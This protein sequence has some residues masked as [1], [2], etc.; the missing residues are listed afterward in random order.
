MRSSSL[1][2][3]QEWRFRQAEVA[4]LEVRPADVRGPRQLYAVASLGRRTNRRWTKRSRPAKRPLPVRRITISDA[5]STMFL[6]T[7][8]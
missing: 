2:T 5:S 3:A 7:I 4:D 8:R 1:M 6:L